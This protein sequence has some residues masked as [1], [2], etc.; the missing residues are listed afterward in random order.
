M[1]SLTH[2]IRFYI[3][4]FSF[5][6][7]NLVYIWSVT[8][9]P[10]P[11]LS[12][13]RITQIYA[14]TAFTFLYLALL[15]GPFCYT[16]KKFSFKPQCLKARRALGVSAFYFALLHSCF[17][18]FGQ[19]GG[20]AGLQFLSD[21]YLLAITFSFLGLCVLFLMTI[22]S[23]DKVI[24]VMTVKKWK[25]LH[26]LIYIAS[27]LILIHALMLGSHFSNLNS[28]I[29]RIIFIAVVFLLLLESQRL[30]HFLSKKLSTFNF[31]PTTTLTLASIIMFLF[32][33]TNSN[34]NNLSLN[35]HNQH[36]MQAQEAM[37]NSDQMT[38][39]IPALIG[40]K[41]KRYNVTFKTPDILTPNTQ[42]PLSFS[43]YNA[44]SGIVQKSFLNV[45]EKP[46]HLII[47]DSNLNN[48]SHIHPQQ[49]NN[50]FT[51]TTSFP[52]DGIYHLYVD[53][54]PVGAIEQQAGFTLKVGENTTPIP[55]PKVDRKLTKKVDDY[56]ITMIRPEVLKSQEISLGK[57]SLVFEV[58]DITTKKAASLMP[59]LM[60]YGHLVMINTTTYEYTHVHPLIL[61]KKDTPSTKKIEFMPMGLLSPIKPGI[62]KLFAQF[63]PDNKLILVEYIIEIE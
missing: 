2:N 10:T 52:K 58:K 1:K 21:T 11:D 5:I 54:Q 57:Q 47:V 48:F 27:I 62:Y 17:A 37:N 25:L 31:G 36:A 44:S 41:N 14:L 24:R 12:T 15:A 9:I 16:F 42:I 22:T 56:E 45:Y 23:T 32:L 49:N 3:L 26:R 18:F 55:Q 60:S 59:Y 7:S 20:F 53:Y 46:M 51:I 13:I 61:A 40:D 38:S 33:S 34:K 43:I 6:F 19:L 8:T 29:P 63:N 30:D 28:S 35:I 4:L 39:Q 50:S